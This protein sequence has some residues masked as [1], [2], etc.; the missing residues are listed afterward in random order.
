MAERP[1]PVRF[2]DAPV[3][4]LLEEVAVSVYLNG[5]HFAAAMTVPDRL[6]ELAIGLLVT[7]QA[8]RSMDEV[9]SVREDGPCVRVLTRDPFRAVVPRRGVITGCGGA[10]SH[11]SE[12]RVPPL[13]SGPPIDAARVRAALAMVQRPPPGLFS[14]ALLLPGGA[15]IA[16][17]DLGLGTALARVVGVAVKAGAPRD[18]AVAALSHRATAE[19]ARAAVIAGIPVLAS[20]GSVTSLSAELADRSGLCLCGGG[21]GD[22]FVCHSHPERLLP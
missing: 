19:L 12:R 9:E 14:A 8:V 17:H 21:S 3:A 13:P 7:E 11:L 16:S 4:G 22:G 10:A 2:G 15:S 18:G 6:A 1:R 20:A 5:R